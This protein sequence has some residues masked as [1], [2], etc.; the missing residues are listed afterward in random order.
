MLGSLA[1]ASLVLLAHQAVHWDWFIDD[2]T[3]SFAF[4]R[5]W[6]AG[7]GLVP[8]P[9]GERVEGYS[10]PTWVVLLMLFEL[11]GLSGFVVGKPMASAFSIGTLVLVY[12][13][14]HKALPGRPVAALTAPFALALNAQFNL[15]A[16][17]ALEN[18]LFCFF[19]ALGV[20]RVL[21]EREHDGVPW[22]AL[23]F[24]GLAWTRPEGLMYAALGGAWYLLFLLRRRGSLRWVAAWL[25]MFWVPY[26]LLEA[27]RIWYFA[28]P[29]A[30]TYYA[31]VGV[32]GSFPLDWGQ[33]GWRQA[34]DFAQRLWHGWFLPIYLLAVFGTRG[35]RAIVGLFTIVGVSL[36]LLYPG[37]E[38][39]TQAF[40]WW[41]DNLPT[42]PWFLVG[43]IYVLGILGAALGFA[44][45]GRRGGDAIAM[46]WHMGAA[47]LFFAVYANGDWMGGYRWMSLLSPSAAVLFSVGVVAIADQ[48]AAWAGE[49][50]WQAAGW[51]TAS[52]GMVLLI[53]P[54]VDQTRDHRVFNHDE[55]PFIVKRRGDYTT[56]VARRTF[57]EGDITNLEMD[58]GAHMWWYPRYREID[59]AG[60]IDIPM[61]RHRYHQRA[62]IREYV[63]EENP[64]TFGHVH[65]GWAVNSGFKTYDAWDDYFE[66]PRYD[67]Q[68]LGW[69]DGVWTRRDLFVHDTYDRSE[70]AE[71][72]V[73]F[74]GGIELVGLHV[75]VRRWAAS[76]YAFVE[77]ALRTLRRT[78]DEEVTVLVTLSNDDG[79][80]FTTHMN[81]GWG[82]YPMSRWEP[83]EVYVGGLPLP[84]PADTPTGP[85]DVGVVFLGPG[86]EVLPAGWIEL[87]SAT[88]SF[89]LGRTISDQTSFLIP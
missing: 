35:R 78:D 89:R 24:L 25:A 38:R 88:I 28:W 36:L 76:R 4:A 10:N 75:P 41:P 18:S 62:F 23:A 31:K 7:E 66:L 29:L 39:L 55:T 13:I 1:A 47:S 44:P 8:L 53:P 43:R 69:H 80:V 11:V 48:V 67:D 61:S 14:T 60:L 3:I 33:R 22:S 77:L 70:A 52:I 74:G 12:R 37:P 71:R 26:A 32:Q 9:G 20:D 5:N 84:L 85:L 87:A 64:P 59:M 46:M 54:N 82:M 30:N 34:R 81:P 73:V 49:Q 6:A 50:E 42:R 16:M 65:G 2:A 51:T 19:L 57:Y 27:L 79:W 83:D 15:W 45:L 21:E 40:S 86:G 68:E 58:Q 17:S 72:H 63:F 56:Q